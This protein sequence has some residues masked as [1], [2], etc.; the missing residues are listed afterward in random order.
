MDHE[1]LFTRPFEFVRERLGPVDVRVIYIDGTVTENDISNIPP[2]LGPIRYKFHD[3]N[4]ISNR[5]GNYGSYRKCGNIYLKDVS[6][7]HI[8]SNRF[9]L[10]KY[11]EH[12]NSFI[13]EVKTSNSTNDIK[14]HNDIFE[15]TDDYVFIISDRISGITRNPLA[16]IPEDAALVHELSHAWHHVKERYADH[17]KDEQ[18]AILVELIYLDE[19]HPEYLKRR[20]SHLETAKGIVHGPASKEA[21]EIWRSGKT[22]DVLAQMAA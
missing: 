1:T 22:I 21:L 19:Q 13:S 3:C 14:L 11:I 12:G 17:I 10:S 18:L 15:T 4:L 6:A 20:L 2:I 8:A 16:G 9:A 5:Q 7:D